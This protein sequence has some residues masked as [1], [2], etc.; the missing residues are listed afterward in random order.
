MIWF[1]ITLLPGGGFEAK[2][3][4]FEGSC[5]TV[6]EAYQRIHE[7]VG[8]GRRSVCAQATLEELAAYGTELVALN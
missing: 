5:R 6:A 3:Y 4:H 1:V 7:Q 8:D 2:P